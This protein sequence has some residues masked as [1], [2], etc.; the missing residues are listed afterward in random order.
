MAINSDDDSNSNDKKKNVDKKKKSER[1]RR[2]SK[3]GKEKEGDIEVDEERRSVKFQIS[4]ASHALSTVHHEMFEK[5]HYN[6]SEYKQKHSSTIKCC[7]D[8]DDL[9]QEPESKNIWYCCGF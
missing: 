8:A 2:K 6:A 5:A 3:R 7:M 4:F 1:R 9:K